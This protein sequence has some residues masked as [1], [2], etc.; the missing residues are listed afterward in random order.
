MRQLRNLNLRSVALF[1]TA[2]HKG[3]TRKHT[4]EPYIMH[5]VRVSLM[6][7]DYGMSRPGIA[8]ALLHD[9]IE[10]TSFTLEHIVSAFGGRVGELVWGLT[11]AEGRGLAEPGVD[12]RAV[13]KS[14]DRE[15]LSEQDPEVKMIKAFDMI[16]NLMDGPTSDKFLDLMLEEACELVQAMAHPNI[17][18]FDGGMNI[19]VLDQFWI[20]WEYVM[21]EREAYTEQKHREEFGGSPEEA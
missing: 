16:D 4:G 12:N 21:G 7:A 18:G 6:A 2:A 19:E 8:A 10:D 9:V 13:R 17:D 3:Q 11:N 14:M 15:W 5:P 1:A 20:T